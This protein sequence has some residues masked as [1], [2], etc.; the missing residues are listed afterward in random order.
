MRFVGSGGTR[1]PLETSAYNTI[2]R[3]E[4]GRMVTVTI[5]VVVTLVVVVVVEKRPGG[6]RGLQ[7][8]PERVEGPKS[9]V[10]SL[11]RTPGG[12]L[13]LERR[14]RKPREFVCKGTVVL[15]PRR[16][17]PLLFSLLRLLALPLSISFPRLLFPPTIAP[18][19][20][21]TFL[22]SP[23][24]HWCSHYYITNSSLA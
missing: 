15:V 9:T 5:M 13:T 11:S 12:I 6:P 10:L 19:P 7:A 8:R 23:F 17:A 18:P 4:R 24:P 20:T 21:T 14:L 22:H 1:T 3:S 2:H 16:V